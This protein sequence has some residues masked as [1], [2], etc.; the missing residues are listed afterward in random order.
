MMISLRLL[1]LL[2]LFCK[3]MLVWQEPPR[4]VLLLTKPID[5]VGTAVNRVPSVAIAPACLAV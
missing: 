4:R 5:Q 2:L 3:V 1:L